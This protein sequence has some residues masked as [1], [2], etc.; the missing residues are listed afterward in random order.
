MSA[1]ITFNH[2]DLEHANTPL[3]LAKSNTTTN[4]FVLSIASNNK[5]STTKVFYIADK[6]TGFDNGYDS[7]MFGGTTYDLAIFTELVSDNEGNKLAIQTLPDTFDA[8][9]PV[10]VI[11]NAGEEVVFFV[12]NLNLPEGTNV[13]LEDKLTGEFVNLSETTY[14]TTLTEDTDSTEQFYIHTTSA[15]SLSTDDIAT[16]NNISIYKS[17]AQTLT[18]LGLNTTGTITMYSLSGKEVF[19]TIVEGSAVSL[20]NFQCRDIYCYFKF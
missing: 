4:K 16:N 6:T 2:S 12:E 14:K 3:S 19:N 10:G 17:A 7:K 20:P 11:A 9:I 13:Y 5:K 15:K 18:I 8:V 1:P